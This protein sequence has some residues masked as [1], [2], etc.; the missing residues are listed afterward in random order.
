MQ[1]NCGES[2]WAVWGSR[3]HRHPASPQPAAVLIYTKRSQ[4]CNALRRGVRL[5][6]R[7]EKGGPLRCS[8]IRART[9]FNE[10][11]EAAAEAAAAATSKMSEQRR[12]QQRQ[13]IYEITF[14]AAYFQGREEA[15]AEDKKKN[16]QDGGWRKKAKDNSKEAGLAT[17]M[18]GVK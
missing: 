8:T 16:G 17:M 4:A 2:F 18:E 7:L 11:L 5:G 15:E 10:C 13:M 12:R 14:A 6:G 9:T 1:K 3:C